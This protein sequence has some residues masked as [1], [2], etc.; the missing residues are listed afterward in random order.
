MDENILNNAISEIQK[1]VVLR[2]QLYFTASIASQSLQSDDRNTL[3]QTLNQLKQEYSKLISSLNQPQKG[4]MRGDKIEI[5][6]NTYVAQNI[7]VEIS[8]DE[9]QIIL[10]NKER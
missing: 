7:F 2:K 6:S 1:K 5:Q 3:A 10:Y 9:S 8:K 4:S